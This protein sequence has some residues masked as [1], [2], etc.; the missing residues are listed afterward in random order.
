M[1]GF[2]GNCADFTIARMHLPDNSKI[3]VIQFVKPEATGIWRRKAPRI[4][5]ATN[6]KRS[7]AAPRAAAFFVT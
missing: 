3:I 4:E 6:V 7:A 1:C 5:A 2:V